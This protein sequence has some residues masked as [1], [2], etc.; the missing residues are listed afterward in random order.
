MDSS[1]VAFAGV[2]GQADMLRRREA[3][4]RDLT[5]LALDRIAALDRRLNAF[6]A[7]YRERA[8]AEADAADRRRADGD[9][10]PLLGVPMAIKDEVDIVGEVTSRGTGAYDVPAAADSEVVRRL[11]AA[12]A[13]VVGKTTMPE[14]GLWPF[15]ESVTWGVTRNPWDVERTPGGSSGGS[16]AAVAAGLVPAALAVDGAGSI[17][18]PAACCGLFGLK[19]QRDRVSRA[20]HDADE[21]HWICVGTLTR[22]VL[23]TAVVLDVMAGPGTGFEAAARRDPGRLRIA[24]SDRFPTGVR[25][26]LTDEVR[27]A[28][29]RTV[30]ALRALG[31]DVVERRVPSRP[32]HVAVIVGLMLRGIRDFVGEVERRNRLERRTRSLA[33][34]GRLISDRAVE[35]LLAGE[36]AMTEHVG[37][38]FDEVDVL[39]TPMM[40]EPARPAQAME[41]RGAIATWLWESSWVPFN[42]LWNATGQPAASVPAGFSAGGLPL[43]VQLVGRH[44]DEATLLS[45]SAQL[46][47]AHPWA[48]RRPPVS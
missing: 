14:L 25:G 42:V 30:D 32:E 11:R 12:G 24:V 33:R 27:D 48:Q 39:L 5:Q 26:R 10:A 22:S 15:T 31:H 9:R 45:L 46:E 4:S 13:V 6:N 20:P 41:G 34:P 47:A 36:Q 35:R 2:V 44:H 21:A 38:L 3:T 16:G 40:S 1:D 43:A 8:L 18:I 23:D 7:V 28:L 19:P 37:G 17:R 29:D